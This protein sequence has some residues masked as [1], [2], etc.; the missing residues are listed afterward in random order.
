MSPAQHLLKKIA[1]PPSLFPTT[2][3]PLIFMATRGVARADDDDDDDDDNDVV[4]GDDDSALCVGPCQNQETLT[5]FP[6][7]TNA[8]LCHL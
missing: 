1:P 3:G 6:P 4:V 7:K 8:P 5:A 2:P